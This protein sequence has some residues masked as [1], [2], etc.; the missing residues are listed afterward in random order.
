MDARKDLVLVFAFD[1][2]FRPA[3]YRGHVMYDANVVY[4][5]GDARDLDTCRGFDDTA[6]YIAAR[7]MDAM[8]ALARRYDGVVMLVHGG[9]SPHTTITP[10]R[11]LRGGRAAVCAGMFEIVDN[12]RSD[13][14]TTEYADVEEAGFVKW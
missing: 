13:G 1:A 3:A 14:N 8:R 11:M 6:C 9:L 5:V 2:T 10:H 7:P 12:T 4:V